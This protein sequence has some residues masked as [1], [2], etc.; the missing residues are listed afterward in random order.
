VISKI[1]QKPKTNAIME[2]NFNLSIEMNGIGTVSAKYKEIKELFTKKRVL[3]LS[4]IS[5]KPF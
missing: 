4:N 1:Q 3:N 2:K 5:I